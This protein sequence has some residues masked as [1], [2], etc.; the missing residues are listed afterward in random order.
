MKLKD[1]LP[2]QDGL[3][4]NPDSLRSM[5]EFVKN[6]GVYDQES[7]RNFDPERSNL[8]YITKFPDGA[9]FIRDG[10]HRSVSIWLGRDSKS[11]HE[12]EFV[13]EEFTY[14]DYNEVAVELGWYTPFDPRIH[15]RKSDFH[16][17][18]DAVIEIIEKNGDAEKFIKENVDMYRLLRT[19]KHFSV[20]K[21]AEHY[22]QQN[23]FT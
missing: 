6:G 17:F 11:L 21:I 14:N 2:T 5:I 22:L 8:I 9:H 1:L 18:K 15:V 16:E 10:L 20:E 4:A 13:I 19:P 3:R 7:I 23:P 12:S